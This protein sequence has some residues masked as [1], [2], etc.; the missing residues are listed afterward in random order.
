M[1]QG[2]GGGGR[3]GL[4]LARIFFVKVKIVTHVG[5]GAFVGSRARERH[6]LVASLVHDEAAHWNR[7]GRTENRKTRP[8][9]LC[10]HG[11]VL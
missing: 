7:E 8:T 3:N 5:V 9:H 11:Y 1:K 2:M 10:V 4:A 6:V